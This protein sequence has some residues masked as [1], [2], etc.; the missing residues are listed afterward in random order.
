MQ[1]NTIHSTAG[2][3]G[4]SETWRANQKGEAGSC[5]AQ[6]TPTAKMRQLLARSRVQLTRHYASA[7]CSDTA[8]LRSCED[9]RCMLWP[10]MPSTRS[11]ATRMRTSGLGASGLTTCMRTSGL[12]ASGLTTSAHNAFSPRPLTTPRVSRVGC[13]HPTRDLVLL[14]LPFCRPAPTLRRARQGMGRKSA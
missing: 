4:E 5:G 2:R 3:G 11:P 12:G 7:P 9:F 6:H 1:A 14:I 13:M 8:Y 10:S